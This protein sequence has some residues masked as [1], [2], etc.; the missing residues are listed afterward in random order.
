MDTYV[1]TEFSKVKGSAPVMNYVV[2]GGSNV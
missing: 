2:Q 1:P